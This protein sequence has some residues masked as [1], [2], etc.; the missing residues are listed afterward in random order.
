MP[1][2]VPA[3]IS[4]DGYVNVQWVTTIANTSAPVAATEVNAASSLALTCYMKNHFAPKTTIEEVEDWRACLRS[5]LT[6]PGTSKVS[7]DP[8]EIVYDVQNPTGVPNKAYAAL[9]PTTQGYLV[10]RYGTDV[11]TALAAADKVDVFPVTVGTRD[12]LP[13]ERNSQLKAQVTFF[14]RDVVKYDVALT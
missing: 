3:A 5:V 7:I 2:S 14:I 9:A 10:L 11:D 8:V 1:T 4:S 12:K 13:P 6:T